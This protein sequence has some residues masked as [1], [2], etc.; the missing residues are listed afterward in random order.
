[1]PILD[2]WENR[3]ERFKFIVQK[4]KKGR[5]LG[6]L[7]KRIIRFSP[8]VIH[9]AQTSLDVASRSPIVEEYH[10]SLEQKA[11]AHRDL[12]SHNFLIGH[13]TYLIDYDTAMYDT[14]LVDLIQMVN[15]KL[16]QQKWTL[17]YFYQVMEQY[18][19]SVSLTEQQFALV[20][21]LLRYPDN[22]MREVI[23]LYEGNEGFVSKKVDAYLT[24]IMKK[25]SERMTFF[26]GSRHFFREEIHSGSQ[27][28]V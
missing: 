9:E 13:D 16:D 7:E 11:V 26:Q 15:R 2:K 19:L 12:A 28:V 21:L 1:M 25:W 5:S 22:F 14:H 20:Y 10:H 3:L 18:Q 27:V 8:Y 23:G 24:M 4:L 6:S 17:D